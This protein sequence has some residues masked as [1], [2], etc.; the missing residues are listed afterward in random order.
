M[1][2]DNFDEVVKLT[3]KADFIKAINES[4]ELIKEYFSRLKDKTAM[5]FEE[6]FN[7]V[8]KYIETRKLTITDKVIEDLFTGC[9][10][11]YERLPMQSTQLI[12]YIEL[13]KC[14][15]HE[16]RDIETIKE[17]FSDKFIE[18]ADFY[19]TMMI[20]SYYLNLLVERSDDM[21]EIVRINDLLKQQ[22]AIFKSKTGRE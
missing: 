12:T 3:Y 2:F 6:S 19:F 10:E 1:N 14:Y 22:V 13:S 5:T 17:L 11:L 20:S 4:P 21:K 18:E 16:D 15:I 7:M 9:Y 8:V